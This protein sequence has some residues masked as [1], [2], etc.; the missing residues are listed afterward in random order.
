MKTPWL[1]RKN[2][3]RH[4][5]LFCLLM[6]SISALAVACDQA[7][8]HTPSSFAAGGSDPVNPESAFPPIPTTE[9]VDLG[10]SVLIDAAS[11]KERWGIEIWEVSVTG[12]GGLIDF[13]MRVLDEN[14]AAPLLQDA[15]GAPVLISERTGASSQLVTAEDGRLTPLAGR[16]YIFFFGNPDRKFRS[17]D[18]ITIVIGGVRLEHYILG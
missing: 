10:D 16:V 6:L 17:G 8:W 2:T 18:P 9:V 15:N 5:L 1:S 14:K 7:T 13:R 12:V 4:C 3:W 11:L